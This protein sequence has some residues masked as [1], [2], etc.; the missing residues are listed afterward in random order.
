MRTHKITV[1]TQQTTARQ[2][3]ALMRAERR[4][5]VSNQRIEDLER[6]AGWDLIFF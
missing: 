2:Q 5:I 1:R 4:L 3:G 6:I